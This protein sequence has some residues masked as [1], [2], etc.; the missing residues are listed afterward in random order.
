MNDL[1]IYFTMMLIMAAGLYIM[2]IITKRKCQGNNTSSKVDL[3]SVLFFLQDVAVSKFF[4]GTLDKMK[5]YVHKQYADL[6]PEQQVMKGEENALRIRLTETLNFLGSDDFKAWPQE[7]KIPLL[8][9]V[10]AMFLYHRIL[11][12]RCLA[13]KIIINTESS[14]EE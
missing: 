4:A 10:G 9:Q 2:H 11:L 1:I 8:R 13:E 7:K 5:G 6:T 3:I 14:E 12:N